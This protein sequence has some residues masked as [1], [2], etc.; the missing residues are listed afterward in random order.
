M[1]QD[2]GEIERSF[3]KENIEN[4]IDELQDLRLTYIPKSV[5]WQILEEAERLLK[6]KLDNLK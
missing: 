6:L 1:A 5:P 2:M 3:A 4:A